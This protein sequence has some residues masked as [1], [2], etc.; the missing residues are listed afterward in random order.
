M[1]GGNERAQSIVTIKIEDRNDCEPHFIGLPYELTI[2]RDVRPGDK[3]INVKA[4]DA[5]EGFN[6]VVRFVRK[7]IK[8][9][10]KTYFIAKA[11]ASFQKLFL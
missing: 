4:V 9:T 7:V 3:V 10:E 6:G 5:D 8:S 1:S 2:S 11:F